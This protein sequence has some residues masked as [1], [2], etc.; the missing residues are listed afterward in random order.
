VCEPS[1]EVPD[2]IA[3]EQASL[4]DVAALLE[5]IQSAYRGE[6]SRAGW[7][8]EADLLDGVRTDTDALTAIIAGS[9]DTRMLLAQEDGAVVAC[10]QLER[11]ADGVAYFGMFAVGPERQGS[12]LGRA[13]LTAAERHAQAEWGSTSMEMTVIAQRLELIDWYE[14][15]GYTCTGRRSPFPYGD[16]RFGTPRRDDLYFVGLRKEL[17]A[18]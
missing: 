18:S 15:R 9:P 3:V 13:V 5:L 1:R 2:R 6:P 7:T 11:R 17:S 16:A 12:G 10:C 4:R 8:T 14:R